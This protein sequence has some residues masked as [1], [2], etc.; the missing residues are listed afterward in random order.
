MC[1][2]ASPPL[3]QIMIAL[4]I[5]LVDAGVVAIDMQLYMIIDNHVSLICCCAVWD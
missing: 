1:N 5:C 4:K 2:H 3:A